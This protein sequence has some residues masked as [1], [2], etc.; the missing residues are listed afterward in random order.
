MLRCLIL[1]VCT[2]MT[3]SLTPHAFCRLCYASL[4]PR[5]PALW[6]SPLSF[7]PLC[8]AMLIFPHVTFYILTFFSDFFFSVSTQVCLCQSLHRPFPFWGGKKKKSHNLRNMRETE[9]FHSVRNTQCLQKANRET[10]PWVAG[11]QTLCSVQPLTQRFRI[12]LQ[13]QG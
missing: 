7:P 10:A 11:W 9:S 4:W 6:S 3:M 2:G 1:S 5:S 12:M 13:S 8:T